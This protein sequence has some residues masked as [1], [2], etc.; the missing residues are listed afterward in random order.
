MTVRNT[1]LTA[2]PPCKGPERYRQAG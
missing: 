2:S 1:T